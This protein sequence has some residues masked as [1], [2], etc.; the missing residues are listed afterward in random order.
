MARVRGSLRRA[1]QSRSIDIPRAHPTAHTDMGE[2]TLFSPLFSSIKTYWSKDIPSSSSIPLGYTD[3]SNARATTAKRCDSVISDPPPREEL[4]AARHEKNELCRAKKY[5]H[6]TQ[7]GRKEKALQ[8]SVR[9]NGIPHD[10]RGILQ[11]PLPK[12][13]R[14][15]PIQS[16]E[17]CE[18]PA[19]RVC[20]NL[21]PLLVSPDKGLQSRDCPDDMEPPSPVFP[22]S[23]SSDG[24]SR[25]SSPPVLDLEGTTPA[26]GK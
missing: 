24:A 14:S 10:F 23:C 2:P 22:I 17:S 13:P 25:S 20:F 16:T 5:Q 15:K 9:K 12:K 8:A 18:N 4:P 6:Q 11:I 26:L 7:D 21:P 3:S 19:K 1:P